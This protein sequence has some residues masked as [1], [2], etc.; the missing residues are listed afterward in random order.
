MQKNR[1]TQFVRTLIAF[2][3]FLSLA[4]QGIPSPK[5][6]H[7]LDSKNRESPQGNGSTIEIG[8]SAESAAAVGPAYLV[9]DINPTTH[10]FPNMGVDFAEMLFFTAEDGVHGE[11]LWTSDGT[12]AGTVLVK[13]IDPIG[14]GGIDNL[15][16][17]NGVMFFIGYDGIHGQELWTSDGTAV[18][19]VMVKDINPGSGGS[20]LA[21]FQDIAGMLYFAADD[22]THGKE[23]WKSDGTEAGTVMVKDI[24]LSGS[25]ITWNIKS[26]NGILYFAADDGI[27]GLELWRSD[28]TETGTVMVKDI[29]PSGP[30]Y[31]SSIAFS[32]INS[33][34]YLMADDGVHGMELWISDG[35][36]SGTTMVK[37]IQPGA[38]GSYW[39]YSFNIVSNG[40]LYFAAN[41]G[42]HRN[43]LWISDGTE[44]GTELVKE[45]AVIDCFYGCMHIIIDGLLVFDAASTV[46]GL[47]LWVSDGTEA[48]TEM[49]KDINPGTGNGRN[50]F[51]NCSWTMADDILYFAASDGTNGRELWKSDGTEAGTSMVKDINPTGPDDASFAGPKRI[52]YVNNVLFFVADDG[53]HGEEPWYSDGTESGTKMVQDISPGSSGSNLRGFTLSGSS[54]FF[55]ADDGV[56]GS[57]L[58]ALPL[59]S[60]SSLSVTGDTEGE[61]GLEYS[62]TAEVSPEDAATPVTYEWQATGQSGVTNSGGLSDTVSFNWATPGTKT[63]SVTASNLFTSLTEEITI[64]VNLPAVPLSELILSGAEQGKVGIEY[65]FLAEVSPQ[66]ATTPITYEWQATGQTGETN[67]VGVSDSVSYTW[68]TTGTKTIKVTASNEVNTVQA[69]F[70]ITIG[71]ADIPLGSMTLSGD[72]EGKV[73][74]NCEFTAQVDPQGATTPITFEWQATGQS[75]VVNTGGL[76]DA[77]T[78]VWDAPGVKTISVTARNGVS[79]LT[80][81]TTIDIHE[82]TLNI[83]IPIV[84]S[85]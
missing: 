42:T 41:D 21:G 68:D 15:F 76:S 5:I 65:T 84:V 55:P 69:Q 83:F 77:V 85:R 23:L 52:D 75:Q 67:S 18:G 48:G 64:S 38:E 29:N 4:S 50:C 30:S 49:V 10:S 33:N 72:Q 63:V 9:K 7:A 24:N 13:D 44:G 56:T 73:G 6:A 11:A 37:D 40:S 51:Y 45:T 71:E 22:G 54:L 25:S 43:V 31:P 12:K 1:L 79:Q 3:V 74:G 19:T 17:V 61:V 14:S 82:E 32:D 28:G 26:S 66:G 46:G 34:L 39:N 81:Q 16:Q 80:Q 60:V 20:L 57:E 58:W 47:E 78:F 36:S 70:D 62:F 8:K 35:T 59:I 2:L 27:H 53:T